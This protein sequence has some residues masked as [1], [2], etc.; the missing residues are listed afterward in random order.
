[1][2]A[3]RSRNISAALVVTF[4]R[5]DQGALV[6]SEVETVAVEETAMPPVSE[7]TAKAS[8]ALARPVSREARS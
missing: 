2:A 8:R 7:H 3:T 1:M 4:A 5:H 6:E